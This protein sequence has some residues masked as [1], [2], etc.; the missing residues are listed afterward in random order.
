MKKQ[1]ASWWA[2]GTMTSMPNSITIKDLSQLY[3]LNREIERDKRR[4]AELETA[5]QSCTAKITGM[6]SGGGAGDK[7]GRY[8]AEIADLRE[9]IS[10]N[11]HRC[12]YE[13]SRLNRYIASIDD[14][15]TRQIFTLRFVNGLPWQQVAWSIGGDNTADGVRK[16]VARYV[17]NH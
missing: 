2:E 15:L 4:L 10:L 14:S 12:W 9:I 5:A 11:I 16:V 8:A 13:L 6:P 17:Q 7:I 1:S 3:Y